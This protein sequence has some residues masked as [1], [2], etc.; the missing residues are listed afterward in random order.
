MGHLL[1]P[2]QIMRGFLNSFFP[3]GCGVSKI[4]LRNNNPVPMAGIKQSESF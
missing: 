2:V 1:P 3:N 4:H